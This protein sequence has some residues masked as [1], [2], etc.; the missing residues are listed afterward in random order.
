M[1]F[2]LFIANSLPQEI[3]PKLTQ[4]L[5]HFHNVTSANFPNYQYSTGI[6]GS[7]EC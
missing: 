1:N 6:A 3:R 5:D 7:A 2:F 4:I